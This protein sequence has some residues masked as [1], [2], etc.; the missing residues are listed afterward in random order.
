VLYTW[1]L[2]DI[3]NPKFLLHGGMYMRLKDAFI[4]VA[5]IECR[6]F[7][8]SASYD[9]NISQLKTASMGRGGFEVSLSWQK[10]LDRYNSSR[11]A[12]RCPRF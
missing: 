4:P 2:D 11:D 9:A 3:E 7:A 10:Y 1:K 12:V 5:K 6:P 8:I